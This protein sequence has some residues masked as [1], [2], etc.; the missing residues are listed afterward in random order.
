MNFALLLPA[1]LAAL[2]ALLFPL[3][4]H[5]ARRSER[6]PT[7]FAA[8]RWLQAQARPRRNLRFDEWLLL[9]LRLLLVAALALLLAKPV[10]FD[11]ADATPWIVAAPGVDRDVLA[12]TEPGTGSEAERRWLA[13]GFPEVAEP[14]PNAPV[15]VG[16]LLRELDAT[17]PAAAPLTVLV[18]EVLD[19]ADAERPVLSRDVDWRIVPGSAAPSAKP[20]SGPAEMPTLHVRHADDRSAAVRYLRAAVAAWRVPESEDDP[21]PAGDATVTGI[22]IGDPASPVPQDAKALVW[23]VPGPLPAAIRDWIE[24][25]GTALIDAQAEVPEM[26]ADA[27]VRWRNHDGAPLVR[28]VR[29]GR[30]QALQ[31]T[32][33]M[34]PAAMPALLE[35]DFPAQLRT[36]FSPPALAPARV[37][38]E[39][40]AP[41][42]GARPWPEPPRDLSP[43]LALLVA[44]LFLV[45]RLLAANPRRKAAA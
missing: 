37:A 36:L 40:Y 26:D 6:R 33:A 30:G 38:A 18:P 15:A 5:L 43:W 19:G 35:A 22:D 27:I 4:I 45:E 2:A 25:G 3:A 29:F 9:A 28:G 39:A 21:A 10:L 11:A 41:R 17:L 13:P 8:L 20:A 16:S 24:G 14:P 1:G 23:L 32:Q 31:W 7:D 34:T 12:E 42:T 44:C